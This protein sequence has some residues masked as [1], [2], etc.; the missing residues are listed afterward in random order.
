MAPP[1]EAF[2]GILVQGILF[3][4]VLSVTSVTLI[5]VFTK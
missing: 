4:S 2:L 3:H 5:T 1:Q